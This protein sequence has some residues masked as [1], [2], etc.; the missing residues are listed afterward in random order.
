MTFGSNKCANGKYVLETQN[1]LKCIW[2]S[3]HT[4]EKQSFKIRAL[5]RA[6][7]VEELHF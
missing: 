4:I 3:W 7:V 1:V 2:L 5:G 6:T